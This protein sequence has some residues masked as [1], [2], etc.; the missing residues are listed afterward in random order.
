MIR[1]HLCEVGERKCV[2]S[3]EQLIRKEYLPEN[4]K[5]RHVAVCAHTS[6]LGKS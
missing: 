5:R 6:A 1:H 3:V 2:V 4:E